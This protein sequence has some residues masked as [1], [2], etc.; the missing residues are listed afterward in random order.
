MRKW[1]IEET[2]AYSNWNYG[3]SFLLW[4]IVTIIHV[5]QS[6]L[7][8]QLREK[9]W[10]APQRREKI[11]ADADAVRTGVSPLRENH[12]THT[13]RVGSPRLSVAHELI[14]RVCAR[15]RF[16]A[17]APCLTEFSYLSQQRLTSP[18]SVQFSS[19][20]ALASTWASI[21]TPFHLNR[22]IQVWKRSL[23]PCRG[24]E[25]ISPI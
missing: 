22:I 25:W 18:S 9:A 3:S 11:D 2:R 15:V 5:Q 19:V 20:N 16:D 8:E 24:G 13:H 6:M 14:S 7:R 21:R 23:H 4:I 17:P 1:K 10:S 12:G